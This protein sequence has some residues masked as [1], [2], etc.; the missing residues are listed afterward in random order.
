MAKLYVVPNLPLL[1]DSMR[2]IEFEQI[3][4]TNEFIKR[5]IDEL[6]HFTVVQSQYQSMGKGRNGHVWHSIKGDNIL[7]SVLIKDGLQPNMTHHF[8]QIAAL[9]IIQLL[10]NYHIPASIKWPN[11]IFV[12]D[13]KIAGILIEA[14]YQNTIQG[15]VIGMGLN[16]N[17]KAYQSMASYL[18]KELKIINVRDKLISS[19][20]NVYR[21]YIEEGYQDILATV[22]SL[23]YL[24][25]RPITYVPYGKVI[26]K[27][28]LEN[29]MI[30]IE[31]H[32][33]KQILLHV[34]EIS[35][36]HNNK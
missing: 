1:W 9:S 21:H 28:L 26:F 36:S 10:Q 13:Q 34:N 33:K 25:D 24:K 23:S 29:G 31:D 3:D 14:I 11:D 16:V 35:L 7:L 30:M 4:S 27:E 15:V 12:D 22:N 5:N 32:N 17:T 6:N 2:I 8:T 18:N 20:K 19:L